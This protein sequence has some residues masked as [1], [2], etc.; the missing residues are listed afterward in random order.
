[1]FRET[2]AAIQSFCV[3]AVGALAGAWMW[4]SMD[5]LVVLASGAQINWPRLIPYLPVVMRAWEG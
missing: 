2:E 4:G 3:L 1:M 5:V